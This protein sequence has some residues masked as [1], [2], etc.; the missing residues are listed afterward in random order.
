MTARWLSTVAA[1]SHADVHKDVIL[2]AIRDGELRGYQRKPG[3]HYRIKIE[4]IDAWL[5]G[6][7]APEELVP[8]ITRR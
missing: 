3:A 1:S 2:D 4:D 8:A 6:K 5:E 7:P